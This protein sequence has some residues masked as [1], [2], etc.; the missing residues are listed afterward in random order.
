[1][2]NQAAV[3]EDDENFHGEGWKVI[4][5]TLTD[6][7]HFSQTVPWLFPAA[8]T[9]GLVISKLTVERSATAR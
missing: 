5:V 7:E 1:M 2:R 9:S 6:N 3:F 8:F 4:F